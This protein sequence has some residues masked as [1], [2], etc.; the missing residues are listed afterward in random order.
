MRRLGAVCAAG[1]AGSIFHLAALKQAVSVMF[2][3]RDSIH[4]S[5]TPVIVYL[6]VASNALI[7]LYQT[8]LPTNAGN[9]LVYEYGL[10]PARYFF[11]EWGLRYGLSPDNYVPFITATFLHGG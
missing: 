5:H 7:F 2:P 6:I 8:M 10:V 4:T 9:E 1:D 3:I 11:P